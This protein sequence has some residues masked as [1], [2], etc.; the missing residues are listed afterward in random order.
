[1]FKLTVCYLND[2]NVLDSSKDVVARKL[3]LR[4]GGKR[5]EGAA[6]DQD[7]AKILR[8]MQDVP[9]LPPPQE[10]AKGQSLK[11]AFLYSF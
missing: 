6:A 2:L 8:G 1:M 11:Y 3:R 7:Q 4:R 9:N 5:E 10:P